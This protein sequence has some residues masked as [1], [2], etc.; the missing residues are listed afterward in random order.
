V[1]SPKRQSNARAQKRDASGKFAGPV[2]RR[3]PG[4]ELAPAASPPPGPAE[5]TVTTVTYRQPGGAETP[6]APPEAPVEPAAPAPAT[7]DPASGETPAPPEVEPPASGDR[8]P[9]PQERPARRAGFLAGAAAHVGA[10]R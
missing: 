1:P 4:E 3:A 5:P 2:Q 8:Q 9:E 7:G 10:H 6:T